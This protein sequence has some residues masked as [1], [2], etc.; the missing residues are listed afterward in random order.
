MRR[1]PLE[2]R[3][4][5][6][7]QYSIAMSIRTL[8]LVAVV[9]LPGWWRLVFGIGAV[10]LP[11]IAVVLANVGAS[12]ASTPITPGGPRGLELEAPRGSPASEQPERA[13][14]LAEPVPVPADP[15]PR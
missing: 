14:R 3:K 1:S 7:R 10:V 6:L 15:H 2:D 13:A 12:G 5:R 9:F 8:C 11:W 4:K